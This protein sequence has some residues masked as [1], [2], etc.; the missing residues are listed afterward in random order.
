MQLEPGGLGQTPC[1]VPRAQGLGSS[2][3]SQRTHPFIMRL[4]SL[5]AQAGSGLH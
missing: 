1:Q 3:S 2:S 5:A 4:G